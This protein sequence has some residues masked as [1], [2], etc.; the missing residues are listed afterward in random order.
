MAHTAIHTL[1]AWVQASRLPSQSYIAPPLLLGQLLAWHQSGDWSWTAFA[2]VQLFGVFDQLY[3]VFANDVADEEGDRGHRAPTLFSGGSRVLVEG[4]L[5]RA[6][7]L[8]AAWGCAALAALCA[9]A[10]AIL[11]SFVAL[12]GLGLIGLWLLHAY[13]FPPLRLSYRGGGELLQMFGVGAL[14]LAL[15]YGAQAGSWAGFPWA[16][17]GV[18][19]PLALSTAVA[20]TLPDVAADRAAAKRTFAATTSLRSAALVVWL[21]VALSWAAHAWSGWSPGASVTLSPTPHLGAI[22]AGCIGVM[23]LALGGLERS[24]VALVGFVGLAIT[25]HLLWQVELI[26]R[27]LRGDTLS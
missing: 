26:A 27:L 6:A 21:L 8:R 12:F 25:A 3:I 17:L 14:L 22:A 9:L 13:S 4:I 18:S 11:Q 19:L 23:G 2:L 1:S 16:M 15:G 7:L 10:L 5:P 24:R 20:T